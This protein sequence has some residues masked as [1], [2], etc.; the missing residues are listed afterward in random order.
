MSKSQPETCDACGSDSLVIDSRPRLLSRCRIRKCRNCGARWETHE[1][2]L[3][4]EDLP[5]RLAERLL[6]NI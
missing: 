2:R 3:D 1:V 4:P 6:G 5:P